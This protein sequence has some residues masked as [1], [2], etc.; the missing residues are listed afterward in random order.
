M[1]KIMIMMFAILLLVSM[2][3][4]VEG[5][6][7]YWQQKLI[8]R[9]PVN[10]TLDNTTTIHAVV[11]YTKDTDNFVK[12][13]RPLEFYVGY[14]IYIETWNKLNPDYSVEFCNYTA[15]TF[16]SAS[17]VSFNVNRLYT[18][19]FRDVK[20]FFKLDDGDFF[21]VDIDCHFNS[22]NTSIQ[23]PASLQ[24]VTPTFE[25]KACQF[26]E[27]SVVERDIIKAELVGNNV[28]SVS[29]TIR[30]FIQLNY[31]IWLALFWVVLIIVAVHSTGLIFVGLIWLFGYLKSLVE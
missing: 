4:L 11:E 17:N 18:D 2:T 10:E 29:E 19:D 28:V 25:C 30:K 5:K 3:S 22:T 27:N 8:D 12:G 16:P 1:K 24:I 21:Q 23:I 20:H 9:T 31:E 6:I 14:D 13:G 15:K 26:Y 7:S